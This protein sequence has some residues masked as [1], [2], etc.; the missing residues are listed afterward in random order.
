MSSDSLHKPPPST[1][2]HRPH[3]RPRLNACP[4]SLETRRLPREP[5]M[6]A[7]RR[8]TTHEL[9]EPQ[10]R[11]LPRE[12]IVLTFSGNCMHAHRSRQPSHSAV[13]NDASSSL[14]PTGDWTHTGPN[15]SSTPGPRQAP[16]M[17][18]ATRT[19]HF[20]EHFETARM[21]F[22]SALRTLKQHPCCFK[23]RCAL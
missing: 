1:R 3:P 9:W 2:T 5:I 4:D 19:H 11:R 18:P 16:N 21:L 13:T 6:L 23:V 15:Q 20:P 14:T 7:I 17:A 22:R 8:A 12:L 10:T